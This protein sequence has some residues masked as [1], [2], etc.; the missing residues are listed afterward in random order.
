MRACF[1]EFSFV[2]QVTKINGVGASLGYYLSNDEL[3]V[4][5]KLSS[6]VEVKF[7][8]IDRGGVRTCI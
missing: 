2:G 3:K 4:R 8:K 7:L 5:T 1:D 6:K